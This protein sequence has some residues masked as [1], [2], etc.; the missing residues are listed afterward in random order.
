MTRQTLSRA[1]LSILLSCTIVSAGAMMAGCSSTSDAT[2][3]A[4]STDSGSASASGAQAFLTSSTNT[5]DA[6]VSPGSAASAPAANA[7]TSA[8]ALASSTAEGSAASSQASSKQVNPGVASAADLPSQAT[9]AY[10]SRIYTE[11]ATSAKLFSSKDEAPDK[12]VSFVGDITSASAVP[13]SMA[14]AAADASYRDGTY[15]ATGRGKGGD[16]PVTLV[17]EGG[18]VTRI[19]LGENDEAPAMLEK[20]RDTVVP[21]I[22]ATQTTDVDTATGATITSE[23]II[24]AVQQILDRAAR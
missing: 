15:Y 24:D 20:A 19:T 16:L 6:Q 1:G 23:A 4:A 18:L 8:A 21:A 2:Q 12:S 11:E 9:T 13:G 14:S 5:A 10:T 3:A 7:A 22:I 17:I